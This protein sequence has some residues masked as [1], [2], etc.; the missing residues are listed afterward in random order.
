MHEMAMQFSGRQLG[1]AYA[2]IDIPEP[3][4][5]IFR[6]ACQCARIQAHERPHPAV[7]TSQCAYP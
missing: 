3:D 2:L 5:P 6:G 4:A 1:Y 7:M